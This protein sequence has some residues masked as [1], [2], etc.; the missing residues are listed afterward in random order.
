MKWNQGEPC[1]DEGKAI[2]AAGLIVCRDES[3]IYDFVPFCGLIQ[4]KIP[5]WVSALTGLSITDDP[6]HEEVLIQYWI[7][8]PEGWEGIGK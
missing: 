1:K 7:D 2:V 6:E 8:A 3:G 5:E 4:W